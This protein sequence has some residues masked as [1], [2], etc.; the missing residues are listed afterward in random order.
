MIADAYDALEP[1]EPAHA[2]G[3]AIA[4]AIAAQSRLMG[5]APSAK[6]LAVRAFG[7]STGT[8]EGTTFNILKGLDWAIGRT[9]RSSI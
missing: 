4:G 7:E 8:A 1:A 9:R 5:V 2:H 3:T 6:I